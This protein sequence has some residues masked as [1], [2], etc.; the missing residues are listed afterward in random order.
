MLISI[1]IAFFSNVG[2]K[3]KIFKKEISIWVLFGIVL[4]SLA[5]A[6]IHM[7]YYED[8]S[9]LLGTFLCGLWLG[10]SYWYT[11]DLTAAIM[12]HFLLNFIVVIQNFW[13]VNF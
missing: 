8:L 12:A 4:T 10:L 5:F 7:N 9:L 1:V 2:F 13:M 11:E 6:G 3:I